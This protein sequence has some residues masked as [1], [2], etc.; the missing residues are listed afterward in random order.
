[1]A[2]APRFPTGELVR[3]LVLVALLVAVVVMKGRCGRA[4]E[5]M[6]RAFDVA[7]SDGGHD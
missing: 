2:R 4:A 6:F 3:I 5:S 7:G 1:M